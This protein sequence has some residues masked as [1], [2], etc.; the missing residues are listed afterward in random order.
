[1]HSFS[2]YSRMKRLLGFKEITVTGNAAVRVTMKYIIIR[3][4]FSS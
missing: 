4:K 1:M 2:G 3:R